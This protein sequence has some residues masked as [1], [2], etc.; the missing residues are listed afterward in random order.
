MLAPR[1]K[2]INAKQY[3]GVLSVRVPSKKNDE[4]S[5][6]K[7]SHYCHAQVG[8]MLEFAQQFADSTSTF[9]CDNKNKVNVGTLAVSRYHQILKIFPV[10]NLA[11]YRD[12]DFLIPREKLIPSG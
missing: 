7:D 9:S 10:S 11:V 12:H 3:H 1:Q 4:H 5:H 8:Y 6:H 2:S